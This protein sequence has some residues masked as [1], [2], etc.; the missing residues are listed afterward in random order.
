MMT[1][2]YSCNFLMMVA[3]FHSVGGVCMNIVVKARGTLLLSTGLC[4]EVT[5][6]G[7]NQLVGLLQ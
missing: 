7:S 6:R 2:S 5:R 3:G 4:R 1:K